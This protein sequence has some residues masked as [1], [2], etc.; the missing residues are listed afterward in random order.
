[1]PD[2]PETVEP[3]RQPD[4][5]TEDKSPLDGPEEIRE[6]VRQS[7]PDLEPLLLDT[8]LWVNE[9]VKFV[10]GIN[11]GPKGLSALVTQAANDFLDLI[12]DIC[13]GRGRPALRSARS[14]FELLITL[15]DITSSPELA[16]RYFR[17]QF[18]VAQQIATLDMGEDILP[19]KQ[20]RAALHAK[21]KLLRDSK[22]NFES[23]LSDYGTGF[24]RAW[25]SHDLLSR[26]RKHG[27]QDEYEFYRLASS[28]LHGSSGG[29]LGLISDIEGQTVHRQGPALELCPLAL[30]YG[31]WFMSKLGDRL[32]NDLGGPSAARLS[33]HLSHC[34]SYWT[35]YRTEVRKIDRS[36]W[37][38][39]AEPVSILPV[40]AF[41]SL[42]RVRRW[43]LWDQSRNLICAALPPDHLP[44]EQANM[45][46]SVIADHLEQRP[47]STE[48]ITM[49][50][51]GA[52]ARPKPGATWQP[53]GTVMSQ[54]VLGEW[55]TVNLGGEIIKGID[56]DSL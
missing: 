52:P 1:M 29:A 3:T 38:S 36:I 11:H 8:Y 44:K 50:V 30:L 7:L 12:T 22:E 49:V 9:V 18:V 17:H 24:K 13:R 39:P 21:K 28:V 56:S 25:A 15:H 26:A 51:I 34:L 41:A 19:R 20:R 54:R 46:D 55:R 32:G 27:F 33:E 43:Y 35:T 42:P 23:A 4:D 45:V 47:T 40:I 2:D 37:P 31:L 53:S 14:L 48:L 5:A 6:M 10:H 16:E